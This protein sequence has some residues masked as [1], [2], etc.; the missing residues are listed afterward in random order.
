MDNTNNSINVE[1]IVAK[2]VGDTF[3]IYGD[4]FMYLGQPAVTP[5]E[6]VSALRE[7]AQCLS[8]EAERVEQKIK[9]ELVLSKWEEVSGEK[10]PVW[11]DYDDD[12]EFDD[13]YDRF[14][15]EAFAHDKGEAIYDYDDDG[16]LIGAAT[17]R[18][19]KGE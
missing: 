12:E 14:L 10:R 4:Q 6:Y 5:E 7:M 9:R 15:W 19:L 17:L 18:K 2:S 3:P 13:A 11:S 16:Q 1:N 8:V